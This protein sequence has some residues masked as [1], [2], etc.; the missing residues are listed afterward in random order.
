VPSH[1]AG[2]SG[3]ERRR[4]ALEALGLGARAQHRPFELSGGE[5][6]RVAVARALVNG[7]KVVF[8][9]EPT[10]ELDTVTAEAVSSMLRQIL[11]E[12]GIT[13]VVATHDQ[14]LMAKA[15]RVVELVDGALVGDK[16][17]DGS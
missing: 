4:R 12:R 17:K 13:V 9:D 10:G 1:I 15:D 5:E 8:A 16:V 2:V 11:V 3:R 14:T 6:Q 7:P